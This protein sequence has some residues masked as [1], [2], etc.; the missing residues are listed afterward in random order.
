[1]TKPKREILERDVEKYLN[2]RAAKA[3]WLSLKF[4]SPQR[5]S[6]PDRILLGNKEK[7]LELLRPEMDF[8]NEAWLGDLAEQLMAAA[9]TFVECKRPGGVPTEGQTREHEKLRAR[10]FTVLVVDSKEMVDGLYSEEK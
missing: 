9:I 2:T 8:V 7:L 3:D 6:V 1:M 10:G 5:R 4:T